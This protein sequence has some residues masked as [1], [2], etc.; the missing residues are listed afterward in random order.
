MP[1]TPTFVIVATSAGDK[2]LQGWSNTIGG[3]LVITEA[4]TLVDS[5][6]IEKIA[7]QLM[8]ASIPVAI[9]S[10]QSAV[11]VSNA[12]L[13]AALSTRLKPADTLT[14]VA[15][16]DTITN[17]VAVTNANLDVALSTR[18][19][20][21]DTLAKVTTI[22]TITNPVA[23]TNA[24]LDAALS[25]RLK[26]ADTL[27]KVATVDTI[28]N[29]VTVTGTVT[30]TP[31]YTLGQK[32][33]AASVPVAIASDQPAVPVSAAALPLPANAAQETGGNLDTITALTKSILQLLDLQREQVAVLKA[34]QLQHAVA[35]GF[36]MIDSN[37]LL[38]SDIPVH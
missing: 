31:P 3:S 6:G 19:K 9:A 22:D 33:M 11:P 37:Q 12:N 32:A 5:A 7:Q 38:N 30:E 15:T 26:P 14:K 20:P 4:V 17:P 24:N 1:G 27:T 10:D 29:P 23:V 2:N 13:D 8:A 34:I 28:T 36:G 21:A 35:Y 25:T 16:V 18:L